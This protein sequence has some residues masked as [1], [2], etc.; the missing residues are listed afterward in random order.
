[1]HKIFMMELNNFLKSV[2]KG[3]S[4]TFFM[5]LSLIQ[6]KRTIPHLAMKQKQDTPLGKITILMWKIKVK[7]GDDVFPLK[8]NFN[9]NRFGHLRSSGKRNV[10]TK[11]LCLYLK[12]IKKGGGSI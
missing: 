3:L 8:T 4:N 10:I 1:M 9:L 11:E 7:F 5:R 12:L 6:L 2:V